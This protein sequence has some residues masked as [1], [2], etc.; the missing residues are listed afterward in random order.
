M[1]IQ[2]S[3]SYSQNMLTN[4]DVHDFNVGDVFEYSNDS[5]DNKS[6]SNGYRKTI[7]G[8]T[9]SK[10]LD[11]ITYK[12]S[13]ESYNLKF[14]F[15]TK[16]PKPIYNYSS[17]KSN[18]IFTELDSPI[19]RKYRLEYPT[20]TYKFGDTLYF[21]KDW[22]VNTYKY[23]ISKFGDY[24]WE[25][26]GKGI[27]LIES[28]TVIDHGW[29]WDN[30]R[31]YKKGN[32]EFGTRDKNYAIALKNQQTTDSIYIYPNPVISKLHI[33]QPLQPIDKVVITDFTGRTAMVVTNFDSDF[34]I[35]VSSIA[36]GLYFF[37][38]ETGGQKYI[39]KIIKE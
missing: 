22:G 21:L 2:A 7:I 18:A 8:K 31:Y 26:F 12:I 19:S 23:S 25:S 10:N 30:L 29:F 24:K 17:I 35:D 1:L 6:A 9:I 3:F 39:K 36:P 16:E 32:I 38:L 4:R 13:Y 34:E 27:G 20:L 15:S 33:S 28:Y 11:S 5:Y 37:T 14:D